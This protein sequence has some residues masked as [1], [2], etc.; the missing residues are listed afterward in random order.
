MHYNE[1]KNPHELFNYDNDS[2]HDLII[3]NSAVD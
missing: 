3:I 1:V 2:R